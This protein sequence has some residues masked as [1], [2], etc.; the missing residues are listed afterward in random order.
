MSKVSFEVE[1]EK[2]DDSEERLKDWSWQRLPS[3]QLLQQ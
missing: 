3:L 1:R 2:M